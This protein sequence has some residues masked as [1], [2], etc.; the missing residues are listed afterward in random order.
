MGKASSSLVSAVTLLAIVAG[1]CGGRVE[2]G[3]GGDSTPPIGLRRPGG[4]GVAPIP[5]EHLTLGEARARVNFQI[6]LL[7]EVSLP[8]PCSQEPKVLKLLGVWASYEVDPLEERQ[9]GFLYNMGIWAHAYPPTALARHIQ[10]NIEETNELSPAEEVLPG[11]AVTGE[12]RGHIAWVTELAGN[13]SCDSAERFDLASPHP[14]PNTDRSE[15]SAPETIREAVYF[16]SES[17]LTWYENGIVIEL[18]G[19][20]PAAKLKEIVNQIQFV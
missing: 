17:S 13:V 7:P 12:V 10:V 8:D 2:N 5:G 1:A 18:Y 19:P 14:S 16:E 15:V 6:P 3:A 11:I 4:L 20:F 9:I